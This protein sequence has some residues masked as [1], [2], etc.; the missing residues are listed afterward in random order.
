MALFNKK[1]KEEKE[2]EK[3]EK[4]IEF[5]KKEY[6]LEDLDG[7]DSK[8]LRS[9]GLAQMGRTGLGIGAKSDIKFISG[10]L[11]TIEEQNWMLLRKLDEISKKL[12]K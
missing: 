6:G 11:K 9:I 5:M 1:S 4:Q 8:R 3:L 7:V 10:Y 12:D 2:Q